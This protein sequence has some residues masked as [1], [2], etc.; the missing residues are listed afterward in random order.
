[1]NTLIKKDIPMI[2]SH[3]D[4]I[5]SPEGKKP[6]YVHFE[7]YTGCGCGGT[8]VRHSGEI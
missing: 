1:M 5:Q 2:I 3:K 8:H 7:G 4:A 6:R